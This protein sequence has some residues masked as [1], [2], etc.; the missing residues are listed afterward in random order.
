MSTQEL[1]LRIIEFFFN[2]FWHFV[3]LIIILLLFK[4]SFSK[5][6]IFGKIR[7]IREKYRKKIVSTPVKRQEIPKILKKLNEE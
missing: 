7:T 6:N 1:I 4:G 3:Q 2:N 5:L